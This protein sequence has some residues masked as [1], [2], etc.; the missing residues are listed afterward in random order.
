PE[1]SIDITGTLRTN[2]G[3][4]VNKGSVRLYI[5]DRSFSA[6]A[7]TD[8]DGR[9]KFSN[10]D[11][12]DTSKVIISSGTSRNMMIMVDGSYFP[13]IGTNQN[14]AAEIPDI[15]SSL[16]AYI[17]NSKRQFRNLHV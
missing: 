3:M 12:A 15:D 16:D 1:Q 8:A 11:L 13:A 5:P 10:L 2:T 17:Q 14:Y 4:P 7:Q 6:Y 9:F